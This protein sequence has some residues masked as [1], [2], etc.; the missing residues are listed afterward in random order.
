M[1]PAVIRQTLLEGVASAYSFKGDDSNWQLVVAVA[2]AFVKEENKGAQ[3][4]LEAG[5]DGRAAPRKNSIAGLESRVCLVSCL[6][7]RISFCSAGTLYLLSSILS[8]MMDP[9]SFE[10]NETVSEGAPATAQ[11]VTR[12]YFLSPFFFPFFF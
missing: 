10:D 5:L 4:P 3:G 11:T 7:A 9:E 8:S 6:A 2:E 1:E 12:H